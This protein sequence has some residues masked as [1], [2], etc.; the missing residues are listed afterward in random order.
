[1][2]E[3]RTLRNE[4]MEIVEIIQEH[5][6]NTYIQVHNNPDPDALGAAH[7][8]QYLL[9]HHNLP[10]Y[11]FYHGVIEKANS[12]A[13]LSLF[14]IV[15]HSSDSLPPIDAGRDVVILVDCQHGSSN[16][17]DFGFRNRIV[18]DHHTDQNSSL[19]YLLK[20]IRP[21]VG[22]TCSMITEYFYE[23]NVKIPAHISDALLYGLIV[24]TANLT[25]GASQL[26]MD[27]FYILV[28]QANPSVINELN[29]SQIDMRDLKFYSEGLSSV[30]K[31]NTLGFADIRECNDSLLGSLGD[32]LLTVQGIRVA[33][34]YSVRKDGIKFSVRSTDPNIKAFNLI[35]ALMENLGTGG[36]HA[37][38]AGGFIPNE[39]LQ[40]LGDRRLDTYIRFKAID[41][42][43]RIL[44]DGSNAS[45]VSQI[46]P[47]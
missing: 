46:G 4:L 32:L 34:V 26:D 22:A 31:Y 12:I 13:M 41:Y 17:R 27:V 5:G 1:M 35:N 15:A 25:R 24:D 47:C 42:V 8:L 36:G 45:S 11:I 19:E 9:K 21:D 29:A 44:G 10:T 18:I 38:M 43:E 33:V 23:N 28:N 16:A 7:G 3:T 6:G 20:D 30:E 14:G 40:S 37:E 39:K 2:L